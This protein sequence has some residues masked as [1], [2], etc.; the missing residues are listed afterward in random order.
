MQTTRKRRG[1]T[2][3]HTYLVAL[4]VCVNLAYIFVQVAA[5]IINRDRVYCSVLHFASPVCH[6]VEVLI[7]RSTPCEIRFCRSSTKLFWSEE[8]AAVCCK[9][10]PSGLLWRSCCDLRYIRRSALWHDGTH[11]DD[12]DD[13]AGY[14]GNDVDD[15]GKEGAYCGGEELNKPKSL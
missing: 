8:S 15:G 3:N 12:Y 14:G 11:D 9:V 7:K 4:Y 13:A 2:V 10:L 5:P 1:V 6:S